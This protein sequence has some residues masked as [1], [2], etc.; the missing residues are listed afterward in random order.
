MIKG[1]C[2]TNLDGYSFERWPRYFVAV[3][4]VGECV[5]AK[6]GR[7]LRVCRVTHCHDDEEYEGVIAPEIKVEL[8]N[9]I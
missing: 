3:P 9:T 5:Q 4:R 2:F 6:S 8:T 7:T 1:S